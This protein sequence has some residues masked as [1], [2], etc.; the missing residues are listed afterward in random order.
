MLAHRLAFLREGE[1][2]VK[3]QCRL[4]HSGS[5]V[6]PI[7]RPVEIVELAGVFEGIGNEGDETENIEV[8][9]SGSRPAAKQDVEADAQ[10]DKR[11]QPQ[12]VVERTLRRYQDYAGIERNRLPE[13]G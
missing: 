5:D 7:D 8:R 13:Q 2:E 10:I 1:N 11:N 6:A 12:P 3:E 9:G 4:Q